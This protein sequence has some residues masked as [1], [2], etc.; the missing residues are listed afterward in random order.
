MGF[1]RGNITFL[2]RIYSWKKGYINLETGSPFWHVLSKKFYFSTVTKQNRTLWH[3]WI[4]RLFLN[5]KSKCH[6]HD[7]YWRIVVDETLPQ[8]KIQQSKLLCHC[9]YETCV[10]KLVINRNFALLKWN[11]FCLQWVQIPTDASIYSFVIDVKRKHYRMKHFDYI[12]Y[13]LTS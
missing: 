4:F 1:V 13:V 12:F 7:C 6:W 11:A 3:Q 5:D 8:F 10:D 2:S 9:Q